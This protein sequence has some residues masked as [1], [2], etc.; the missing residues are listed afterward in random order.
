MEG[1]GDQSL[2]TS[3]RSRVCTPGE[4]CEG[5]WGACTPGGGTCTG[6]REAEACTRGWKLELEMKDWSLLCSRKESALRS[7]RCRIRP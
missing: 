1:L 4:D 6:Q 7:R 3:W 2:S 5:T